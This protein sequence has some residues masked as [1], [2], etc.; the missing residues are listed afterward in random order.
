MLN[1][2]HILIGITGGIAAYKT[3]ELTR[4][5]VKKGASV[6][7][8]MTKNATEFIT[9][10][11]LQ[12]LSRHP[13]YMDM[14]SL[15]GDFSISHISLAQEADLVVIAP[16]TANVIGKIAVGIADDLLTTSVMATRAPVLICPSMNTQMYENPIVQGNLEKLAAQGY[17]IVDPSHGELACGVEG[18]GRLPDVSEIVDVVETIL[19]PK[20]LTGEHVLVTAGPTQEAFDPVRF[21]TNHSSG[22]MGYAVA[23]MARRRGADVT[24]ISGPTTLAAPRGVRCVSVKSAREM[25]DAVMEHLEKATVVIKAAAVA[26][27]RPASRSDSKIKKSEGTL[28]MSLE[29]NPDIIAEIGKNKGQRVLIGFAMETDNLFENAAEKLTRKNMDLIIAND[30]NQ[31]GA[32]FQTDTNVITMLDPNG[33]KE[34][35]PLM[36]KMDVADR[37]LD[38]VKKIIEKRKR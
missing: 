4:E 9:P 10:L 34:T 1:E 7:V 18:P 5:L 14:Y 2:K 28:N 31:E 26:D 15:S 17:L 19:T 35:L 21:I 23:V 20:D 32:G 33:G 24:L 6:K 27:Y 12:T 8:I 22:K 13:V 30:L 36:D 29:R 38:R 16:A 25:R 11:T 37:I 3:A